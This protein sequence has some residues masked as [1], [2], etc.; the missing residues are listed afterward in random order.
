MTH[1]WHP[2]YIQFPMRMNGAQKYGCVQAWPAGPA[3]GVTPRTPLP[4]RGFTFPC[5][6]ASCVSCNAS[7]L[8]FLPSAR[9]RYSS[10]MKADVDTS[11]TLHSV[12]I[13]APAPF[14]RATKA[15][16]STSAPSSSARSFA[17]TAVSHAERVKRSTPRNV[18]PGIASISLIVRCDPSPS[19]R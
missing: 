8:L 4:G 18:S 11:F 15:S 6:N 9:L 12:A 14:C 3:R 10:A 13:T 2:F 17:P 1:T 16:P 5:R 7:A 19:N